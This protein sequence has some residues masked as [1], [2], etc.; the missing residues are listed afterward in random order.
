MIKTFSTTATFAALIAGLTL[1]ISSPVALAEDTSA[2]PPTVH[3]GDV[4][5][6]RLASGD[7]EF[8]VSAASADGFSFTQWGAEMQSDA[9]WNPT[10]WRSLTEE[11]GAPINYQKPLMTFPFPLT[12]G[13]TWT[14]EDK[15]QIPDISQSGRSD[16]EGKVGDWEQ[17]TVP[18]GTFRAI[19]VEVKV[20]AIG[21][22]G[23]NNTTNLTYWYA[24]EVNRFVKYHYQDESQGIVDAQ[25]VSYKPVKQ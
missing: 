1:A 18:A 7:K 16:V 25:L 6:D 20:R 23:L 17:V 19:K 13:K 5:V 15:W 14:A 22:L 24:P 4:W 2:G 11:Q 12:P 10:V 8:K 9:N 21:R 3:S